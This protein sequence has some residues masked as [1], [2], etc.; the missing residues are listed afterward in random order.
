MK[1]FF[2]DASQVLIFSSSHIPI[3]SQQPP[4]G[5]GP[6]RGWC[7]GSQMSDARCFFLVHW[8]TYISKINPKF[9]SNTFKLLV[10]LSV[11]FRTLSFAFHE[12]GT[13]FHPFTTQNVQI[14]PEGRPLLAKLYQIS[15][16]IRA[17]IIHASRNLVHQKRKVVN[18]ILL[19]KA[20]PHQ[21]TV[22]A[23]I[24]LKMFRGI[25]VISIPGRVLLNLL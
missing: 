8:V 17:L 23:K 12:F 25:V 3:L 24:I 6:G 18:N 19:D 21:F 9:S 5:P 11:N 22:R 4:S 13:V 15:P 1:N 2:T 20:L 10:L 16:P 14:Q 7:W